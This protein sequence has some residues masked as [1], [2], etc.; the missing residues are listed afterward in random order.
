MNKYCGIDPSYSG[1]T[2]SYFTE[3]EL[4]D[5]IFVSSKPEI[6]LMERILTLSRL[7]LDFLFLHSI[8]EVNI[9][10]PFLNRFSPKTYNIQCRLLQQI[11]YELHVSGIVYNEFEPKSVKKTFGSGKMSKDEMR[12]FVKK[13]IKLCK[14]LKL[15]TLTKPIQYGLIDSLAIGMC[16][17]DISKFLK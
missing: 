10:L 2:I 5:Y 16:G 17:H 7:T 9:E 11:L 4:I 8:Q 13:N 15:D 6:D 1:L 3:K 14:S 12:E